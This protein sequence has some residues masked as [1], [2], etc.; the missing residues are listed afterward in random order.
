MS[1]LEVWLWLLLVMQP[2]NSRTIDILEQCGGDAVAAAK[3]IR[4]GELPTLTEKERTRAKQVRSSHVRQVLE[5]CRRTGIRIVTL[6][7]REYPQ[8]LRAIHNPPLLLFVK[9]SL[10]GLDDEVPVAVIGSRKC[11]DYSKKVCGKISAE[12]SK[13][14]M[15]IVSGLA[16]GIDSA[17]HFACVGSGGRT[18]GVLACG[19]LVNYP[20]GSAELKQR[21]VASGGALVS[22]LLPHASTSAGY[23]KH[24]NRI[25]SGLSAGTLIVEVSAHSGCLLTAEHTIEQGRD[26]FC[27]PPHDITSAQYAGV[28][29]LLRDGA[30]PVF[31]YIDVVNEYISSL[32]CELL[33]EAEDNGSES[34]L[35]CGEK[36]LSGRHGAASKAVDDAEDIQPDEPAKLPDKSVMDSL[37]PNQAAVLQLIA[38]KPCD[39]DGIS[40]RSG[41]NFADT[42]L[43]L[44]DL[45]VMGYI[46]R[47]S[48]GT[49]ALL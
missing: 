15:P 33:D 14:G 32:N 19:M 6:E 45:E 30:I 24:R 29:P 35:S 3:L 5:L 46:T 18:I 41:M 16:V 1:S 49:Y 36:P 43:V 11:S 27:I 22:E 37:E 4:D 42:T 21:I 25:I 10:E 40:D 39:I 48:D 7:D 23:F 38:E 17:A 28:A 34:V 13:L 2:H 26:L 20:A 47:R 12:L 44:T 9:G 31:S 8:R